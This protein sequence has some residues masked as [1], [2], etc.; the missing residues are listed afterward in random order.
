M[1][2]TTNDSQGGSRPDRFGRE[3]GAIDK[4]QKLGKLGEGTYG[5]VYKARNKMTEEVRNY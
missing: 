1:D 5:V 4:Y 3:G 2:Y